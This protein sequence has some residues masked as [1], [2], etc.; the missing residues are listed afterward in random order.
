LIPLL[1]GSLATKHRP[2]A[3]DLPRLKTNPRDIFNRRLDSRLALQEESSVIR[4]NDD[5]VPA[6]DLV[7]S[8]LLF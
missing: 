6:E 3:N 5:Q 7:G 8:V 1:A 4:W 2:L